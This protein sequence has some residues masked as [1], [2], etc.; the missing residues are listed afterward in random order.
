M[1]GLGKDELEMLISHPVIHPGG[2][3][4]Q[5][6]RVQS[7]VQGKRN[8]EKEKEGE[9]KGESEYKVSHMVG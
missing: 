5:S 3:Y 8:K 2:N 9:K 4:T 7:K 1:F 6:F